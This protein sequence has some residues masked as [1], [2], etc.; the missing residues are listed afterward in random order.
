M[1]GDETCEELEQAWCFSRERDTISTTQGQK[2]F[3]GLTQV[4]GEADAEVL[5]DDD[6]ESRLLVDDLIHG[7]SRERSD[8]SSIHGRRDLGRARL[9]VEEGD[10]TDKVSGLEIDFEVGESNART[11][12]ENDKERGAFVALEDDRLPCIERL[13]GC[14]SSEDFVMAQQ[15]ETFQQFDLQ[16]GVPPVMSTVASGSVLIL[17]HFLIMLRSNSP[18]LIT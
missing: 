11:T 17:A 16:H 5:E 8:H 7:L 9:S 14:E 6:R 3:V 18:L 2:L 13:S 12:Q 4:R 10:F 15:V 1:L